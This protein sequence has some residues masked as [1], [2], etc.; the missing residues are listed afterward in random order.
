MNTMPS[1]TQLKDAIAA[2]LELKPRPKPDAP[3]LHGEIGGRRRDATLCEIHIDRIKPD[4]DQVR[5]AGKGPDDLETQ[6]L[7]ES[8]RDKGIL[9]PLNVR[10]VRDGDYYEIVAGERRYTAAK[11]AGLDYLPVKILNVSDEEATQLQLI[12]NVL[13]KDLTPIEVGASL[14]LMAAR[15]MSIDQLAKLVYKGK[16]WVTKH[17]VIFRKLSAEA[18]AEAAKAPDQ[19][20]SLAHLYEVAQLPPEQQTVVL[21]RIREDGLTRE[22]LQQLLSE[23]KR[24]RP[25]SAGRPTKSRPYSKTISVEGGATVVV[26][27][28]KSRATAAE[29]ADAL[30][31]A[32]VSLGATDKKA[33]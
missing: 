30:R 18:K 17:L 10:Y 20:Q 32:L 14:D 27:F 8:I 23:A 26:K 6:R 11:M 16:P 13:R 31:A 29:V 9:Q 7:A 15:G 21:V 24:A 33:A 5:K 4:P 2:D 25:T 3:T 1:R 28:R 22:Q 19:F 12:E